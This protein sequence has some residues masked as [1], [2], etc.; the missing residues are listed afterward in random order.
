VNSL[1]AAL[2]ITLLYIPAGVADELQ[3]FDKGIFWVLKSKACWS[4]RDL[5]A[6]NPGVKL[7][8]RDA[9]ADMGIAVR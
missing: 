9:V 5:I 2:K 3:P 8:K 4:F 7:S 6:T 1:T